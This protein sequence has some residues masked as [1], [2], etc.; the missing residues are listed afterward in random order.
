MCSIPKMDFKFLWKYDQLKGWGKS[1]ENYAVT[2]RCICIENDIAFLKFLKAAELPEVT[3]ARKTI[4]SSIFRLEIMMK[5][6]R[7]AHENLS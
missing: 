2:T 6:R 1:L 4:N 3:A 5:G 7:S